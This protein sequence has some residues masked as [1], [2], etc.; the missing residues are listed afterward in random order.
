MEQLESSLIPL[1][2]V[3]DYLNNP[4]AYDPQQ[5]LKNSLIDSPFGSQ[6]AND[7]QTLIQCAPP[8]PLRSQAALDALRKTQL[9]EGKK[10][11]VDLLASLDK[12]LFSTSS[13][14]LFFTL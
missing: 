7:M 6:L 9:R 8:S 2:T 1:Y 4:V 3:F 13:T 11:F 5:S 10:Y 12:V 14:L